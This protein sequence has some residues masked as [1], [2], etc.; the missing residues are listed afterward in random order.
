MMRLN[1]AGV[2]ASLWLIAWGLIGSDIPA[3]RGQWGIGLGGMIVGG[4]ACA[5]MAV[6]LLGGREA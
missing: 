6:Y 4:L 3:I 1:A 2:G 5:C